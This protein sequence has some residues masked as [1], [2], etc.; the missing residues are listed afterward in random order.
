MQ[1]NVSVGSF[2]QHNR[3]GLFSQVLMHGISDHI[4]W[5]TPK[6]LKWVS[7]QFPL[8]QGPAELCRRGNNKVFIIM[9][10]FVTNFI[11][12]WYNFYVS[13]FL[14]NFERKLMGTCIRMNKQVFLVPLLG[15]AHILVDEHV[16]LVMSIGNIDNNR[17]RLLIR[18]MVLKNVCWLG[19]SRLKSGN[20][21]S[22]IKRYILRVHLGIMMS[23]N[24]RHFVTRY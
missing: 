20:C 7:T 24:P 22:E 16:F 23:P 5:D 3:S 17:R 19:D 11:L 21:S 8:M 2:S 4:G 12:I 1:W 6:K 18:T 10:S 15:L 9:A 13:W 14:N